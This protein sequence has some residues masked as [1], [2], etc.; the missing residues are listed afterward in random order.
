MLVRQPTLVLALAAVLMAALVPCCRASTFIT[1]VLTHPG[2]YGGRF[3]C[4]Y[5][6]IM[7]FHSFDA[8]N[9]ATKYVG[10]CVRACACVQYANICGIYALG[11]V[12]ACSHAALNL[13]GSACT[14][15]RLCGAATITVAWHLYI[16]SII[17]VA[18]SHM[19]RGRDRDASITQCIQ[20]VR[21]CK[22]AIFV[23]EH[24]WVYL[25]GEI[26]PVFYALCCLAWC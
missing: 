4:A 18:M 13:M 10:F 1:Q 7:K 26:G 9:I 24:I 23:R 11:C 22:C 16:C 25:C 19:G 5:D 17:V 6:K 8:S 20:C 14:F 21:V 3:V 12:H 2:K 15:T